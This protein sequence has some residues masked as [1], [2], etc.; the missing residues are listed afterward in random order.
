MMG[1][2][3]LMVGISK[4]LPAARVGAG[5]G[6]IGVGA[7]VGEGGK[8]VGSSVDVGDGVGVGSCVDVGDGVD[9]GSGVD[10][11]DG[12]GV[13][14]AGVGSGVDVGGTGVGLMVRVG[15]A[16]ATVT[17]VSVGA[18]SD[19]SGVR[20]TGRI[21]VAT[22][23]VAEGALTTGGVTLAEASNAGA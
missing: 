4:R 16:L 1:A 17:T 8:G 23:A 9:V 6:G 2:S 15:S 11:G 5:V 19:N 12:V 22:V 7:G 13:G 21:V 20:A 18:E 14:G 3:R 10:V